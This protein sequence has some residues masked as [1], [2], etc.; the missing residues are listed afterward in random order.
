MA[1]RAPFPRA[2]PTWARSILLGLAMPVAATALRWPIASIIGYG[3]PFISYFPF[4]LAAAIW[5]GARGGVIALAI[6]TLAAARLFFRPGDPLLTWALGSFVLSGGFIV[7]AGALLAEAVRVSRD[8]EQRLEAAEAQLRVLVGELAHRGR[9]AITVLMAIVSQSIRRAGSLQEAEQII[10]ARLDALARAQ[11]E[12]LKAGGGATSLPALLSRTLEPFDLGRFELGC[13]G[14]ALVN[15]DAAAAVCLVVHEL[16]TNAVKYGA[17]SS[18]GRVYVHC[19]EAHGKSRIEW[20]ETGGPKVE[21]PEAHGFGQRLLSMA[22]SPHGGRATRH[23][24]PNGV[25]CEIEI[26]MPEVRVEGRPP[27]RSEPVAIRAVSSADVA[28]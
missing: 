13:E 21:P 9:N 23:F 25:V 27:S 12:V 3:L 7:L 16:A 8:R 15:P 22:L 2:H 1:W 17:L 4:L 24:E 26:P 19:S 5:G 6:S 20:R 14:A 10:N 18:G 11:D 28:P